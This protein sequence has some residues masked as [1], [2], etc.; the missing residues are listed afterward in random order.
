MK[1]DMFGITKEPSSLLEYQ[2]YF[3]WQWHAVPPSGKRKLFRVWIHTELIKICES[4]SSEELSSHSSVCPQ[5]S[6]TNL[7]TKIRL[8]FPR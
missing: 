6:S 5:A 8:G 1:L 2:H 3:W 7:R 4:E